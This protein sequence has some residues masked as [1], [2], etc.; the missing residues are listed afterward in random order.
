[1]K[2][3]IIGAAGKMGQWFTNYFIEKKIETTIYDIDHQKI[4]DKYFEKKVNISDNLISATE[5]SDII[6]ISVPIH[7]TAKMVLDIS[8]LAKD[9][10][11]IIEIASF[12][13][14][15]INYCKKTIRN[16]V[17][18]LSIHPMFGPGAKNL[19]NAKMILVT[20]NDTEKEVSET[21]KI[22]PEANV[23]STSAKEH[24]ESMS[25]ILSFT[26]FINFAYASVL[27]YKNLKKIRRLSGT[28]FNIQLT[29]AEAILHDDPEFLSTLQ[30]EN[31]YVIPQ[32]TNFVNESKDILE[33]ISKKDH[34][35]LSSKLKKLKM[36]MEKDTGY[37]TAYSKMYEI[38]NDSI[39][40]NE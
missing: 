21:K 24:D 18:Y 22:F 1:M 25:I 13:E 40:K 19:N 35:K 30:I 9:G 3:T 38:I 17:N 27:S 12:K 8:E 23:I 20:V 2:V 39:E 36:V 29:I 7:L 11:F 10:C 14:E 16:N 5:E 37:D 4:Q 26:Q 33:L 6:L 31:K 34:K 15:I 28:S 32:I